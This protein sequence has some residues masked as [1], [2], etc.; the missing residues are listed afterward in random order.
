[1]VVP[2]RS[3]AAPTPYTGRSATGRNGI[4]VVKMPDLTSIVF[5]VDDDI[6]VRES[7]ELLIRSAGW[8]AETFESGPAFL[9]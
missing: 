3:I 2:R 4:E 7:L 6:S 1:M 8:R 5:V 9:S